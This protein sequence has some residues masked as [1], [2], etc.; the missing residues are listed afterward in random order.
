MPVFITSDSASRLI[1]RL[2]SAQCLLLADFV[3]EVGEENGSGR[4]GAAGARRPRR[5][6]RRLGTNASHAT[7]TL[8]HATRT[9][10]AGGGLADTLSSRRKF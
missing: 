9:A 6:E 3:A 2:T 1:S 8:P 10:T 7:A 5:L 4:G